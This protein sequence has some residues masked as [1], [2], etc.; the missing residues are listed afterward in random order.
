MSNRYGN[1]ILGE[2]IL[3]LS[4]EYNFFSQIGQQN[5]Y[6]FI[7]SVVGMATY[8]DCNYDEFLSV[9]GPSLGICYCCLQPIQGL[10]DHDNSYDNLCEKCQESPPHLVEQISSYSPLH[11]VVQLGD[12]DRA[13]L[14]INQGVNVNCVDMHGIE[15]AL[16][17]AAQN[18]HKA[19]VEL[20][21]DKS[22]NINAINSLCRTPLHL[23]VQSGYKDVV[24]LLIDEGANV[25]AMYG[26][27]DTPLNLAVQNAHKEI[28]DL[29]INKGANANS[30]NALC[31][32][33]LHLAVQN[34]TDYVRMMHSYMLFGLLFLLEEYNFFKKTGQQNTYFFV[35]NLLE[36]EYNIVYEN[37]ILDDK[38]LGQIGKN[39]G[40]CYSCLQPEQHFEDSICN[41]C[42]QNVLIPS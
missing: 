33:P 42:Y 16:H 39:I 5:T 40:I 30:I 27:S 19:I 32:A 41:K 14:L 28:V 11:L 37:R 18:G 23:A 17:L 25:N 13:E 24:E 6:S 35:K 34:D 10:E 36:H 15:T 7:T 3:S 12:K 1:H 21:I 9:F 8:H 20:L 29:L 4:E 31:K 22:A 2:I 38:Y 26:S